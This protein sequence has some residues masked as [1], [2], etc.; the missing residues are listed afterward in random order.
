MTRENVLANIKELMPLVFAICAVGWLGFFFVQPFNGSTCDFPQFYAPAR[1]FVTGHSSE[2]YQVEKVTNMQHQ[3]F[4]SMGDRALIT[5]LPPPSLVWFLP[6]G[7][8]PSQVAASLWKVVQGA[9]L[10]AT[11]LLLK[12][13]F[14]LSRKALCWLIAILFCSGPVFA[15]TL[16]DQVSCL[17]LC[18]LC[19]VIWAFKKEKPW[20][21][22]IAL[23]FL[24]MKPQEGLPLL[25]FLAGARRYKAVGL[26]LGILAA[27]TLLVGLL[28]GPQGISDYIHYAC[29]TVGNSPQVQAELGPTVRG[30]L[31]RFFPESKSTIAIVSIV[32][33]LISLAFIFISG[34]RFANHRAWLEAGLLIA[35]P[36]GLVTCLHLHSYDLTLLAPT[37]VAILA[38]PLENVI[39]P[40]PM[41]IGILLFGVF[42]VPFYIFIHW[43]YLL[44]DH[45]LLNPHFVVLL[46][47]AAGA[48]YLAYRYPDVI[49]RSSAPA[50]SPE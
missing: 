24:M 20:L 5:L 10:V 41:L 16:I 46:A 27:A 38:G 32:V 18:A 9:S 4:P 2:T 39:P 42:I 12:N 14:N 50:A 36:L 25:V 21:L 31:L 28:I 45:W 29:S 22:A 30:Q 26:T 44:R 34:R 47:F 17:L 48:A 13:S 43:D 49:L 3:S 6:F 40:I 35:I 19:I 11:I 23:S 8:L 7:C 1:L 15:A 33:S 37:V